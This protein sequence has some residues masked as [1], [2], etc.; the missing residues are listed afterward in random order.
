VLDPAIRRIQYSEH[1]SRLS[2]FPHLDTSRQNLVVP[3]RPH[4][5]RNKHERAIKSIEHLHSLHT[6]LS[7]SIVCIGY[8]EECSSGSK[9]NPRPVTLDSESFPDK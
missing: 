9:L 8:R 4:T 5:H 6:Q 2:T 3:T 7:F 1:T